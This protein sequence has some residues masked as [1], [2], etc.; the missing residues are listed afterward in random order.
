MLRRRSQL[1]ANEVGLVREVF[2]APADVK[3]PH[4]Q[5]PATTARLPRQQP[6]AARLAIS[7]PEF[8]ARRR[9]DHLR[10]SS[11]APRR[12]A[13]SSALLQ[14]RTPSAARVERAAQPPKKKVLATIADN[15]SAG[16]AR[17]PPECGVSPVAENRRSPWRWPYSSVGDRCSGS[18]RYPVSR[19]SSTRAS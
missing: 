16:R 7:H 14:D 19:P 10:E 9:Q 13:H 6:D 5:P 18:C 11:Q 2:R 12:P 17:L 8:D 1:A 15:A 3:P 4:P